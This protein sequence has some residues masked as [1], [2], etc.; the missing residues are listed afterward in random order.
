M[1]T[2]GIIILVIGGMIV[3]NE[4]LGKKEEDKGEKKEKGKKKDEKPQ[5]E[6]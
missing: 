1:L 5:T 6:D 2:L 3:A 4:L